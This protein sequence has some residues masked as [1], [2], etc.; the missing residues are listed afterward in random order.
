MEALCWSSRRI[1]ASLLLI[2]I[3]GRAVR[4][5]HAEKELRDETADERNFREALGL[6][7][8][9][10]QKELRSAYRRRAQETHPDKC[11]QEE[12]EQC[13]HRFV[14]LA[15]AYEALRSD[16]PRR[17]R[18]RRSP[19]QGASAAAAAKYESMSQARREEMARIRKQREKELM[20]TLERTQRQM[21]KAVVEAEKKRDEEH[22]VH[23]A[24]HDVWV[25]QQKDAWAAFEARQEKKRQRAQ[26]EA[27]RKARLEDPSGEQPTTREPETAQEP[28]RLRRDTGI[29]TSTSSPASLHSTEESNARSGPAHAG[30]SSPPTLLPSAASMKRRLQREER[31]RKRK[32][33]RAQRRK[34]ETFS[35]SDAMRTWRAFHRESRHGNMG[36]EDEL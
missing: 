18:R 4:L 30:D 35:V 15:E 27:E 34:R 32:R 23:Q 21:E 25:Q 26:R 5:A 2:I 3:L 13:H 20:E 17:F 33:R 29:A 7:G 24:E 6:G 10:S 12:A 16:R 9:F 22:A 1:L 14:L 8:N 28:S 19:G 31:M 11:S 36:G